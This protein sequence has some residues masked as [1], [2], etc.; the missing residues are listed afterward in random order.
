V[1]GLISE[2]IVVRGGEGG[3]EI[4][5]RQG[6]GERGGREQENESRNTG[7][8]HPGPSIGC[9]R[10]EV[11]SSEGKGKEG[12]LTE[13]GDTKIP[14]KENERKPIVGGKRIEGASDS[15]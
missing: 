14:S 12:M 5:H 10:A 4:S 3:G 2:T 11:S 15:A 13:K 9:F 8:A 6:G 1:R 7:G